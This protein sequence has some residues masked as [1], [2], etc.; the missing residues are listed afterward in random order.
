MI[1]GYFD[2]S[3]G[4]DTGF[5]V[6]AGFVGTK[7]KWREYVRQWVDVT[8][9]R[10]LHMKNMRL[11]GSKGVRHREKLE[12]LA[13]IPKRVGLRAFVGSV[14]T[15]DYRH[16]T[17][18]TT[19]ELV[20]N[21]YTVALLAM[22]NAIL[23]SNLPKKERIEF[24]FEQQKE[25]AVTRERVFELLRQ[26]PEHKAHHGLSRIAKSSSMEKSTTLEASDYLAYAILYQLLEP[27]SQ[28]A[29]LTTPILREY[30]GQIEH[31]LV[32]ADQVMQLLQT[33]IAKSGGT[34]LPQIDDHRKAHIK[35]MLK[36][37][38]E[39]KLKWTNAILSKE[40]GAR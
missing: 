1:F 7:K 35:H 34:E 3:G 40:D 22:V 8:Q 17:V 19:A 14:R 36:R 27:A 33:H 20:L 28:Q 13:V 18:G 16:L 38:L 29:Q 10:P 2:E 39:E 30:D 31:R 5:T 4:P 11:G 23:E 9:G 6:V 37:D 25:H 26:T 32:S 15:S 21:G 12:R 24:I